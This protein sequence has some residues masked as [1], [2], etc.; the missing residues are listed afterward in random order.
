MKLEGYFDSMKTANE[1]VTK[2]KE[3]GYSK[4]VLDLNQEALDD[5][6]AHIDPAGSVDAPTLSGL[7]LASGSGWG[8]GGNPMQAAS[9]MVSGM[10]GFEEIANVSCKVIVDT[11][12]GSSARAEEIIH[13]MGGTL[14][15]PNVRKPRMTDETDII[16]EHALEQLTE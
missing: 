9:P 6:N 7:V 11:E 12:S 10:G 16:L 14:D 15:N 4:A 5:W 8:D 13:Q 2:L 1:T 3:A